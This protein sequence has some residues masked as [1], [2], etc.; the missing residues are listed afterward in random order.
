MLWNSTAI[1]IYSDKQHAY[2]ALILRLDNVGLSNGA[3]I[4]DR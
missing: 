1:Y 4:N 3:E 2:E